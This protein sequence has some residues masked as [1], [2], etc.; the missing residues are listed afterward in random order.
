MSRPLS[1]GLPWVIAQVVLWILMLS[2]P[3]V[4]FWLNFPIAPW[5]QGFQGWEVALSAALVLSGGALALSSVF[6]LGTN[7]SPLPKP[8]DDSVL[9][10]RGPYRVLRHPIYTSLVLLFLAWAVIW[11]DP[12]LV[13]F[14]LTLLL[15]FASKSRLE[16]RWLCLRYPD[17]SEY[18]KKTGRLVPKVFR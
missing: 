16:E 13:F 15:L 8:R 6:A 17:Y 4:V 9:V 18:Q 11:K 5:G 3:F 1:T 14:D 12:T 10:I 7:L 2:W